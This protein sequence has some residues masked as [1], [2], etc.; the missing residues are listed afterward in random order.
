MFKHQTETVFTLSKNN[1]N[2]EVFVPN[3]C[4]NVVP[5]K[6]LTHVQYTTVGTTPR[7]GPR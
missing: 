1:S 2:V 5:R 7:G 4:E 3:T 6:S